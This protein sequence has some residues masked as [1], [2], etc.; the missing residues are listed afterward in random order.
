MTSNFYAMHCQ[1][2]IQKILHTY[3][4]PSAVHLFFFADSLNDCVP[5]MWFCVCQ[6]IIILNVCGECMFVCMCEHYTQQVPDI[7]YNFFYTLEMYSV[8]EKCRWMIG[9]EWRRGGD[10]HHHRR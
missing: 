7:I 9:G 3:L 4:H 2:F 10:D 8:R 1:V 6:T 5:M